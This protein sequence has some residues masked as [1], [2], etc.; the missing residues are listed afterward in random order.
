L[1]FP[2]NK[3]YYGSLTINF[4]FIDDG[5]LADRPAIVLEDLSMVI[6]QYETYLLYCGSHL[7]III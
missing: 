1:L 4:W 2:L 5:N 3:V 7:T 6:S